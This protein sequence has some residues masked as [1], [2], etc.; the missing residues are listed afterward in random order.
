MTARTIGTN[1]VKPVGITSR[2]LVVLADGPI[3]DL[4]C[5]SHAIEDLKNW[6]SRDRIVKHEIMATVPSQPYFGRRCDA[7]QILFSTC[8]VLR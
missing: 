3:I 7:Y 4:N 8:F 2:C 6:L 1:I 5:R